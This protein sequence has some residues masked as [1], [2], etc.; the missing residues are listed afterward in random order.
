MQKSSP[1]REWSGWDSNPRN[2]SF[3]ELLELMPD[4]FVDSF[5]YETVYCP[6][7]FLCIIINR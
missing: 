6:S 3:V 7:T 5:F 1:K 4:S 2:E